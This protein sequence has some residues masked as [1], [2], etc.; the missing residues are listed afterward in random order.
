VVLTLLRVPEALALGV[1]MSIADVIPLVGP[2]IGTLPAVLMALSRGTPPAGIVLVTYLI[3]FQVEGNFIVPRVYGNVLKL[4][5]F[6]VLVAFL[7]GTTLLGMLGAVLALPV[8]AAIPIVARYISE[9]RERMD[10]EGSTPVPL[11]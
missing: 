11:P 6:I 1:L 5:P 8:A 10:A 7:I 3:Y 2:L 9:W 4:S